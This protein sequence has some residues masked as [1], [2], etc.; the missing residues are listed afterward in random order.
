MMLEGKYLKVL[1]V[2]KHIAVKDISKKLS[3]KKIFDII[4]LAHTSLINDFGIKKPR[5]AV[6]SL[7]PHAGEHGLFGNE[8]Q[9]KIIPA[10]KKA[11]KSGINVCGPFAADTLFPKVKNNF[12]CV[13]CMYHDQGLI[14]LKFLAFGCGVNI[15][16]GLPI[17]RTSVD[18]GTAYDI[19]GKNL[20][21]PGSLI[22]AYKRSK[23]ILKLKK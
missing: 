10:I 22:H 23:N 18:H 21:N 16:V 20:A 19:V 13:V 17:I 4:K 3:T 9:T 15:T 5:I 6:T 1:L 8:E 14:P 11:E 12:D 2:T 7:N